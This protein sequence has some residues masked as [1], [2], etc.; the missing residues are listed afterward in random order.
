MP[1]T[2]DMEFLREYVQN[3]S[4]TA[5]AEL[6][7][8]HVNLVYSVALRHVGIGAQ[9]EEITQ[10]VFIIL[11]RKAG[12]LRS[13]TVLEGWLHTTTRLTALSFLRGERRRQFREQ[14]A[15]MQSTL[16]ESGDT[17]KDVTWEQLAPLLDE[18]VSRLG[19]KDRDLLVLRFFKQKSIRELASALGMNESAAQRRV[20]R[21][22]EKLRVF[23]AQRGVHS[24]S[25]M[26]AGAVTANSMH[27]APPVLAK[28]VT[29]AAVAKGAVASGSTLVLVQGTL[30][31]LTYA[32]LKLV[33][34]ITTGILLVGGAVTVVVSSNWPTDNLS[35]SEIFH[36]AQEKYASL[37]SYS[38][39]GKTVSTLN[40]ITNTVTFTIRLSRPDLYR[41]EWEQENKAI[42]PI[43]QTQAVWSA[44][45][46]DFMMLNSRLQVRTSRA[47]A[48]GFVPGLRENTATIIPRMFFEMDLNNF[49]GSAVSGEKRLADEKMGGVNCYVISS[50]VMG[51]TKT[52]WI[53]KRDFLIHQIQTATAVR[54][55]APVRVNPSPWVPLSL[56]RSRFP[57]TIS[58]ETHEHILINQSLSKADFE[59][60]AS[61]PF[62]N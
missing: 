43:D 1:E 34:G 9:A 17:T 22:L 29:A 36:K 4:E 38:D 46:G 41:I 51:M 45:A 48:L 18:A 55:G 28:A 6:V 21:A 12:G 37:T 54:A 32:K 56:E 40:E 39:E 15:F 53:G 35:A 50:E 20:L 14:E 44:G 62:R 49:P 58:T 24:T 59:Y 25:A 27:V 23:F 47:L 19:N 11:A 42:N 2:N 10:A 3:G 7:R 52:V 26:L 13:N 57:G 31:I 30:K 16:Q 33:T 5:F 8:R 60:Q 61:T